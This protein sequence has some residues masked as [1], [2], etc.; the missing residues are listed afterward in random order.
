MLIFLVLTFMMSRSRGRVELGAIDLDGGLG[1]A[2]F[3]IAFC[4][5]SILPLAMNQFAI[6]R[7]GLT[8]ALLSPITGD[9]LLLG[10][11]LGNAIIAGGPGLACVAIAFAAF[12]D[13]RPGLWISI[14]IAFVATYALVAPAAAALSALFPRSVDLNSIGRGSNA[15]GVAG[16][17]G[18]LVFGGAALP[19]VLLVLAA[20]A[21]FH[22]PAL[23]PLL[24]LVWAAIALIISRLLFQVVRTIFERRKENL[25]L[26]AG[27]VEL[28]ARASL[29]WTLAQRCANERSE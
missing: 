9:A 25:A 5:I 14:P 23:A 7:A 29:V 6:D 15:H 16:L 11:A 26:V 20:Q 3:G 10:K 28:L 24:L 4:L 18:L 13:G 2:L 19:N 27:C 21:L 22:R 17:L 1:L 8:L 12:Y